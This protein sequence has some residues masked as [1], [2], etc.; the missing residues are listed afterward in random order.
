MEQHVLELDKDGSATFAFDMK[1]N[2]VYVFTIENLNNKVGSSDNAL[3]F[4]T[5]T[6]DQV[7]SCKKLFVDNRTRHYGDDGTYPRISLCENKTLAFYHPYRGNDSF[8]IT[9]FSHHALFS[10]FND[11]KSLQSK[12]DTLSSDVATLTKI[13][14]EI[15][16][17]P[18]M[19]GFVKALT[20]WN[21]NPD[22]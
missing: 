12:F 5:V 15:Y 11:M 16:Y 20:D 18:E 7:M 3:F 6:E 21:S 13:V 10:M 1:Y 8:T 9:V 14:N 22:L 2:T 4:V 19:P 17:A